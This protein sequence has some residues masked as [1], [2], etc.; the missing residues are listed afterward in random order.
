MRCLYIQAAGSDTGKIMFST[1][2]LRLVEILYGSHGTY[3]LNCRQDIRFQAEPILV[4][5]KY[6]I[7]L[8]T[9]SR[10]LESIYDL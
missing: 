5:G 1:A 2:E 8:K 4:D 6:W 9:I 10:M 3:L 7:A